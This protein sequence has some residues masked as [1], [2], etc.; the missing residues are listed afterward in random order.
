MKKYHCFFEKMQPDAIFVELGEE[1]ILIEEIGIY[2][3]YSSMCEPYISL[4]NHTVQKPKSENIKAIACWE[5]THPETLIEMI[6]ENLFLI[7]D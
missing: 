7:S 5:Y 3:I 4:V 6:K 2:G 1:D